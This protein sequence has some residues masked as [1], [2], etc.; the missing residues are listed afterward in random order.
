MIFLFP[1][2]AHSVEIVRNGEPLATI[3]VA[4]SL[5]IDAEAYA[6]SVDRAI[7]RPATKKGQKP[8]EQGPDDESAVLLA[9]WIHKMTGATLPIAREPTSGKPAI[10][11]GYAALRAGLKLDDIDSPSHEGAR[12]V[13]END[14]ILI[15][16]QTASATTRAVAR[17]L[18]EFGCRVFMDGE[19]GEEYPRLTTL[20]V[21]SLR[22]TEKPGFIFR[23]PKGPSWRTGI[24]RAWNGAGGT[25]M[26]HSHSWGGYVSPK[27]F[28]AHPDFFA[29]RKD[30]ERAPSGWLCTSNPELRTYF[31][32]RV[33][34]RIEAGD[35][36]P[37]LSPSDGT[38][39]C[40]CEQCRA[41]DDPQAI[42]PSSG[43]PAMTNRYVNFFD[44]VAR[45]V[46]SSHPKSILSF[47]CYADY[48]QPPTHSGQLSPNLCAFIAP[49]RYCRLHGIGAA[50]CP[51]RVQQKEMVDGWA[52]VAS[53][54][55]YYMYMYDL[56]EATVPLCMIDRLKRD[57]PYLRAKGCVGMTQEVL[58]NWHIYGPS[59]Y[60]GVRLMYDPA[61]DADA[62]MDDY[63][64]KFYGP[65]AA[66]FMKEYW[67]AI[68]QEVAKLDCHSG[69]F[70][71][72]HLVYTPEFL[73]RLGKLL[74]QAATATKDEARY[75]E[76]V[77]LHAGGY[78]SAAEYTQLRTAMIRGDFTQAQ[79]IYNAS[80]ERI[81]GLAKKGWA[82]PEYGSAYLRRFTGP[83][84]E[85]GARL[86][87]SPN[88][89]VQ[90]LPDAWRMTYDT[91]ANGLDRKLHEPTFDDS[92]WQ[93]VSTYEKTLSAQGLPDRTEVMWY[94]TSFD[95]AK[96][97]VRLSLFFGEIDGLS[98]VYVNGQKVDAVEP[99]TSPAA[100]KPA[101]SVA[102]PEGI[103]RRTPFEVDISA[104]VQ[105]GKNIV[106]VRVDHTRITE[107]NLGGII[108]PVYVIEKAE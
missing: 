12:I 7:K 57:I 2:A 22:I 80:V 65:K 92:A 101:P 75:A 51:Q 35:V 31:A 64:Q 20:D 62:I 44:D 102:T 94:R 55:G 76:R 47:Y 6:G 30:G 23:N 63:Y 53:K 39:Y 21:G 86:L 50:N 29:M 84:V 88:R 8:I 25:P 104:T 40:Q 73:A 26:S 77:A 72:I 15:A 37:S 58:T 43:A 70:F 61:A 48:T 108:R 60:L 1:F 103:R 10:Y 14:R 24:W 17:F 91:K 38:S 87:A 99:P 27:E 85:T 105:A 93:Q 89:L 54:L 69:S 59:L 32:K 68:D 49:I 36:N 52:K 19:I 67:T 107:L 28:D 97:P 81:D 96:Q 9:D 106:A 18:E 13:A 34:E 95:L 66:P 100:K 71:W 98:Q 5:P 83:T 45:R 42:E 56:A 33:S 41:Q 4:H 74:G 82:N 16:G 79:A 78:Q 90:V 3:V 11:V 46:A